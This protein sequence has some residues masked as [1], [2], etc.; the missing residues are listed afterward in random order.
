[1][2]MKANVECVVHKSDAITINRAKRQNFL[3]RN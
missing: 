1:V 2:V 3:S